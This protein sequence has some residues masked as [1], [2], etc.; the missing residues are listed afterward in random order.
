[1]AYGGSNLGYMNNDEGADSYD[2]GAAVGQAGDLRPIYYRVKRMGWGARSFA[3]ILENSE[4]ATE[5]WKGA[6]V[7]NAGMSP[8]GGKTDT[9]VTV[10]AEPSTAGRGIFLDKQSR[11]A[12]P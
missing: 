6:V 4:D 9:A 7:D 12:I 8:A 5:D 2:Y 3:E 11:K 10:K 1:M